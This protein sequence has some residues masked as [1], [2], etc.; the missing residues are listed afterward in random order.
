M[1]LL[2]DHIHARGGRFFDAASGQDL[3]R[4]KQLLQRA[5]PL[6]KNIFIRMNKKVKPSTSKGRRKPSKHLVSLMMGE[7]PTT[8]TRPLHGKPSPRRKLGSTVNEA[9]FVAKVLS[10]LDRRAYSTTDKTLR[11]PQGSVPFDIAASEDRPIKD[12]DLELNL[13]PMYEERYEPQ[14][15]SLATK[16]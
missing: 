15:F 10:T 13:K 12:P 6:I 1:Q 3:R 9:T 14:F 2:V 8:A 5:F 4:Q 11:V 7:Y 16:S